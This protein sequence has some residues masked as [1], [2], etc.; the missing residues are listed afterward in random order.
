MFRGTIGT[1][2]Q[3]EIGVVKTINSQSV[4]VLSE[5]AAGDVV[6]SS[7]A[8]AVTDAGAGY[9]KGCVHIKTDGGVGT[10]A[11]VNE[12]SNSSCDFNAIT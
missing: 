12:G 3:R 4:K 6:K 10:T 11:Y 9:A 7:G 5:D 1:T 8:F 2:I